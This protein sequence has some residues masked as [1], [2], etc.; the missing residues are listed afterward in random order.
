MQLVLHEATRLEVTR[1]DEPDL[2][3]AG[4]AGGEGFGPLQM[5]AA[6]LALC[7]ASVLH[8][9]AHEVAKIGVADL[10]IEVRWRYGAGPKRVDRIETVIRWPSLPERRRGTLERVVAACTVH[11]TLEHPPELVTRVEV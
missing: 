7:T 9:H 1:I 10:S 6:S 2:T 5:F 3:I 4:D 11:R 8:L